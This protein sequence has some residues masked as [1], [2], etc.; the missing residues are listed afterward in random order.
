M[1]P[2]PINLAEAVIEPFWDPR[3]SGL[4]EWRIEPGTGHGLKVEQNWCWVNVSWT[5]RPKSG[6][7]L[8][9][10][11]G[12]DC[13]L[14]G[15]DTLLVSV[16]A[17]L[18]TVFRMIAETDAGSF[19]MQAEPAS[20]QKREH[21]LPMSRA[22]RLRTLTLEL[23]A[24]GEGLSTGWLN[25]V[26]LQNRELLPRYL[27]QWNRFDEQWKGYLRP[28]SYK[29]KFKPAYGLITNAGELPAL[30][31]RHEQWLKDHGGQSQI[32][33]AV[34]ALRNGSPPE[35][36]IC[37]Y[38]NVWGDD[39]YNRERDHGRYVDYMAGINAAVAGLVLEDG[40]LLR[41]AAR[42]ALAIAACE[43]WDGGMICDFPGGT[44]DERCFVQSLC[45]FS[46]GL[47]LDL[48]GEMFTSLGRTYLLQ[49]LAKEGAGV[50]NFNSWAY[51][52]IHD[53]N[54]LLWFTPGRL[55]AYLAMEPSWR[56]LKPYIEIAWNEMTASL[57]KIV[58]PDGGYPEGPLYFGLVAGNAG[59]SSVLY[60]RYADKSL[61][62][63]LP[64]SLR[65]CAEFGEL[66]ASTD[67]NTDMIP[68]G[69]AAQGRGLP[70][71]L[72]TMANALPQSAWMRIF[73]KAAEREPERSTLADLVLNWKLAEKLPATTPEPRPFVNLPAMGCLAS[74]RRLGS[75]WVKL[76]LT[77]NKANAGHAHE[78]K[79][80]FVLEY[81]GETFAMD[82]GMGSY[83]NPQHLQ[84]KYCQWHNM[85]LPYGT[86]ERPAPQNPLTPDVKP[87]GVGDARGFSARLDVT[88]GWEGWSKWHRSWNSPQPH[89]LSIRDEW[90]LEQGEGVE[91]LW[92]TRLAVTLQNGKV[93]L[94]GK[95]GKA[96]IQLPSGCEVRLEKD[97]G[98]LGVHHRVVFRNPAK[99]GTM[100]VVVRFSE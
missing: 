10:T 79:G 31:Q 65:R 16:M 92:Q 52:Y 8:R 15:Y 91:F 46:V 89:S 39:R 26:G 18:G 40:A 21:A 98:P 83:S 88:P 78:D 32:L 37:Q 48:A 56:R 84:L 30:R 29:P 13:D 25:W 59:W 53:C 36:S 14:S 5:R 27:A 90:E 87:V 17:P 68:I 96:T 62:S 80:S 22:K 6:P 11:R 71:T 9:M 47:T 61:A 44:F 64:E 63:V 20:S 94:T 34:A 2:T 69:D 82:P 38:A 33:A 97:V 86:A 70:L 67:E 100:E 12:F 50:I 7:A 4:K 43:R 24:A 28:E 54:Q 99:A 76:L 77:G 3:L 75:H 81:A 49:R 51:D 19:R 95:R 72:V 66:L 58:L 74:T 93:L 57:E 85:L 60:S 73:R 41:L 1:R 23:D 42:Y 55:T 45:C 35:H